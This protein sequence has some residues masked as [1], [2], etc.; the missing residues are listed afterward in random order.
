M[1]LIVGAGPTGLA[2]AHRLARHGVPFRIVDRNAGP[3]TA[4]RAMVMHARSLELY[5]QLELADDMVALGIPMQGAHLRSQTSEFASIAFGDIGAGLSPY[6]FV[7]SL[8]QDEQERFLV[9]RLA[10]QGIAI[11]WNTALTWFEDEGASVRVVL[12]REGKQEEARV[13]F[14]CGCDG[15][16][17][18]VRQLL[19]LEFPGGTYD[20]TF[21]VADVQTD[22]PLSDW[23]M[24]TFGERTIG[25][26]FPVRR[27]GMQRLIGIVPPELRDRTDLE[28]RD[29]QPSAESL[30]G[31][32][33]HSVNWFSTYRVHHRVAAHFRQ[34][35]V[36]I[37]GDAGHIHSPA[38]GQGMNT[39][40]GDAVNLSWKLAH[41]LQGRIDPGVLDTY[42]AERIAF[43]RVLVKS[44]DRLF[45]VF[46][47]RN[48]SARL[49][50]TVLV[51]KVLPVIAGFDRIR[52]GAFSLVS[53]TRIN[54][55]HSA[56]SEGVA[57][58]VRGG[59]RLPWVPFDGA[60]NFR[61][62]RSLN[63]Q[64]HVYGD[65]R[66]DFAETARALGLEVQQFSWSAA[67]EQPGL[68]RDAFYLVR[69]DGY[70]A[71]AAEEQDAA[72]MSDYAQH[73][74]LRFSA[75]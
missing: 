32:R 62:L 26:V 19:G 55:E 51:P 54:Y 49:F 22:T 35:R 10:Q 71:L 13:A 61:P 68:Q 64:V 1:V 41:V 28:F 67:A 2:L 48:L 14:V 56:L 23:L 52:R 69:P 53:Q 40:I 4:S 66:P 47:G 3:G 25:L 15:A 57:G 6:P 27:T 60:D 34:G 58:D 30:L 73:W 11:E 36:F 43:A 72:R 9:D 63:W 39:G 12:E 38:G 37:A 33:V 7:L 5:Q 31:L 17:S 24:G 42:E 75:M 20:E 44:T 21:Y 29:V 18:T 45:R 65:V 59:D 8:A 16:H 50:R 70:V 46:V 74:Q